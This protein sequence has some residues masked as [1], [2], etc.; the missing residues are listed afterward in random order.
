MESFAELNNT[1]SK[2]NIELLKVIYPDHNDIDLV[3]GGLAER[4]LSGMLYLEVLGLTLYMQQTFFLSHDNL[5]LEVVSVQEL[6]V[7][8]F[9]SHS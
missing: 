5:C 1:I 4:P 7:Y 2:E 3:V 9:I 6:R 8:R